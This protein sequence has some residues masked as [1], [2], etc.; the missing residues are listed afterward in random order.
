MMKMMSIVITNI[1]LNEYNKNIIIT[2]HFH[3]Q[4]TNG[5]L[6]GVPRLPPQQS[7]HQSPSCD[8]ITTPT[9]MTTPKW[10][11]PVPAVGYPLTTL[12]APPPPLRFS[13]PTPSTVVAD[14]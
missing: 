8:S 14:A 6:F 12:Q 11:A 1:Q 7:T 5:S 2:Q 4:N 13:S 3:L 10:I 9:T